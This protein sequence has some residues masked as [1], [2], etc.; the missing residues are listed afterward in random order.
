MKLSFQCSFAL[1]AGLLL[2]LIESS[3]FLSVHHDVVVG[4]AI[5]DDFSDHAV[6]GIFETVFLQFALPGDDDIPAFCLQLTPNLLIA[7]L[8]AG[9][10][11]C[12]EFSVGFWNM[13]RFTILVTM[14]E[15]AVDED[16]GAVFGKDDIRGTGETF[17]IHPVAESQTP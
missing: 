3:G 9:Y 4:I 2:F 13:A 10:L 8:I 7:L 15:A 14:P 6:H 16:Y 11:G 5:P 1:F 12:P 17:V